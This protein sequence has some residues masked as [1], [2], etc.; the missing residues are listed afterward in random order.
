[1][2]V[3]AGGRVRVE[4]CCF[5][6]RLVVGRLCGVG[7]DVGGQGRVVDGGVEVRVV[8]G[9]EAALELGGGR[10]EVCVGA[11]HD[12]D[13]VFARV[14]V[15]HHDGRRP[16]GGVLHLLEQAGADVVG[17]Q[18]RDEVVGDRVVVAQAPEE[19][20]REPVGGRLELGDGHGAVEALAAQVAFERHALDRFARPGEL[21]CVCDKVLVQRT[22]NRDWHCCGG[23]VGRLLLGSA[24]RSAA[25]VTLGLLRMSRMAF[26]TSPQ[27]VCTARRRHPS[28]RNT[29][30][31]KTTPPPPASYTN[32]TCAHVHPAP[33]RRFATEC[34]SQRWLGRRWAGTRTGLPAAGGDLR[35]CSGTGRRARRGGDLH[36]ARRRRRRRH[37]F[38]ADDVVASC[39]ERPRATAL[40]SQEGLL[41]GTVGT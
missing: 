30:G 10:V 22:E 31:K 32:T 37:R 18:V 9:V 35:S 23:G 28:Q 24:G 11:G 17:L 19:P 26:S 33:D 20:H 2:G 3:D 5:R 40:V 16:R 27:P 21:H 41:G 6:R 8:G 34:V 38:F 25:G 4:V 12:D 7:V 36:C 29:Q 39:A 14:V 1:M 15:L 13:S